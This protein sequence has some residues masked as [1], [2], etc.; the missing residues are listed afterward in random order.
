MGDAYKVATKVPWESGPRDWSGKFPNVD[1]ALREVRNRA[2]NHRGELFDERIIGKE[3]FGNDRALPP[4]IDAAKHD[5]KQGPFGEVIAVRALKDEVEWRVRKIKD[6]D[7]PDVNLS[8]ANAHI[9]AIYSWVFK[10]HRSD[11]PGI[12]N[13]GTCNRRYIAGSTTWSE[14]SPWNSPNPGCNAIDINAGTS[15]MYE[16]SRDLAGKDHVAKILYYN[17]EWTKGTGWIYANV[18]HYDH[19]HVE[20]PRDHGGLAGA[21]RY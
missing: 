6:A 9:D 7:P 12:Q 18:G 21:C 3:A 13:W 19:V 8:E 16:L 11:Y 10:H 4:T 5:L 17:H 15:V 2:D 20:G 1:L 14:H